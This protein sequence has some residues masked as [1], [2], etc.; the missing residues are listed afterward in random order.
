MHGFEQDIAMN[1]I[2]ETEDGD[3]D[4]MHSADR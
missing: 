2:F 4:N 1:I 3:G